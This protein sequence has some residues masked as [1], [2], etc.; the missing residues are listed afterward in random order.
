M[1]CKPVLKYALLAAM[2]AGTLPLIASAQSNTI[3]CGGTVK[4]LWVDQSGNAYVFTSWRNDYVR[5]CNVQE[6]A[7]VVSA[8]TC[9]SWVALLKSAVQ[10]SATTTIY[11]SGAGVPATCPQ[12]ATYTS[13]PIPGYVML[14]N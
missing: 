14:Q 3:W 10:R 7:G 11:Y 5:V 6:S 8:T 13:A 9:L 4:N 2:A 1:I 12:M